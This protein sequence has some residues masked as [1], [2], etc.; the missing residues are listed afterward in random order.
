M[1]GTLLGPADLSQVAASVTSHFHCIP[2]GLLLISAGSPVLNWCV[3]S[4]VVPFASI[5]KPNYLGK[6]SF[7][8]TLSPLFVS[9]SSTVSPKSFWTHSMISTIYSSGKR[10]PRFEFAQFCENCQLDRAE[11]SMLLLLSAPS[12]WAKGR[13]QHS[14][15]YYTLWC[16]L[17]EE[18][19]YPG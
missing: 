17:D 10:S 1:K 15:Q 13:L 8:F 9:H 5:F 2:N 6:W 16:L 18:H 3:K 12:P 4:T 11:R 19:L 7:A 14:I